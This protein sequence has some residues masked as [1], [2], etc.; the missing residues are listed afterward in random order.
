MKANMKLFWLSWYQPTEDYRPLT[1]PPNP[2]ILG[3][4]CSGH[5]AQGATICAYVEAEDDK[6]ARDAVKRDW[7]E[8]EEWRFIE[9]RNSY[10][11]SDRFVPAEWAAERLQKW[12][13]TSGEQQ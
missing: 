8:A 2:Q 12:S 3:W 10:Q 6:S 9:E 7:P 13:I 11:T 5:A 1:S 4:W